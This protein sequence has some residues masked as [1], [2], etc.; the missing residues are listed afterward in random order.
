[1]MKKHD[2]KLAKAIFLSLALSSVFAATAGAADPINFVDFVGDTAKGGTIAVTEDTIV[3]TDGLTDVSYSDVAIS[4][5]TINVADGKKLTLNDLNTITP[6]ITG[7]G[8]I[9]I[10]VPSDS[11]YGNNYYGVVFNNNVNS[12]IKAHDLTITNNNTGWY[13]NAFFVPSGV[14]DNSTMTIE[15]TG[16]LSAFGRYSGYATEGNTKS[17]L[18]IT[19]QNVEIVGNSLG[20]RVEGENNVSITAENLLHVE[21]KAVR[22]VVNNSTGTINLLSNNGNIEAT[23]NGAYDTVRQ[24]NSGGTINLTATKGS[25][26]LSATGSG[27]NVSVYYNGIINI[28]AGNTN[29]LETNSGDAVFTRTDKSDDSLATINI[30]GATNTITSNAKGIHL[31]EGGTVKVESTSGNNEISGSTYAIQ[32]QGG[33]VNVTSAASNT[34]TSDDTAIYAYKGAYNAAQVNINGKTNVITSNDKAINV[35]DAATVTVDGSSTQMTGDI[36]AESSGEATVNFKDAK[37]FLTGTVTT[38]DATTNLNFGSG[39]TWNM[40]GTSNVTNLTL[41]SATV[42][43]TADDGVGSKLTIDKSLTGSGIFKMNLKYLNDDKVDTYIS[44][45]ESDFVTINGQSSGSQ[46]LIFDAE[47]ANLDAMSNTEDNS[48]LFFARIE[49]S[50]SFDTMK[51]ITAVDLSNLYDKEYLLKSEEAG[52][53]SG[54]TTTGKDYYITA[55]ETTKPDPDPTPDPDPDP[56]PTP[57]PSDDDKENENITSAEGRMR[58]TYALATEMD[59]LNKRLGESRY[60]DG[61]KG[62]W[63]RYRHNR[64]GWENAYKTTGNMFQIGYDEQQHDKNDKGKHVIGAAFDYTHAD[65]HLYDVSGHGEHK[66][67][68][69]SLY[70]TWAGEKGHY[71]DIVVRGGVI[72]SDFDVHARTGVISTDSDRNFFGISGEYGYKKNLGKDYYFEPQGQLQW[73]HVGGSGYNTNHGVHVEE[74]SANSFLGRLGF[75]LGKE[76]DQKTQNFYLKADVLHEFAGDQE[77]RLTGRSEKYSEEFNGED[78]WFDIGVGTNLKLS[79][80]STFWLDV[81]RVLGSDYD[82]TWQVNGGFRWEF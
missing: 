72:D 38:T 56:D 27:D 2:K 46:T 74:A 29:I 52:T 50:A 14:K 36:L 79:K 64:T 10:N 65:T 59:R 25:N 20:I 54:Q 37:S 73:T 68:G 69:F 1:M 9:E 17:D 26:I 4:Q 39:S 16:D 7:N 3:N 71:R 8:D 53:S 40:T 34:I 44:S 41:N 76:N 31:R 48:K 80:T 32:A 22:A 62:V 49:G 43:M 13:G 51:P 78:T 33:I 58:A 30:K 61:E 21:G 35:S 57:D 19:A 77:Y 28:T 42:D 66:R 82:R 55:K 70:D 67:Y 18:T 5:Y 63:V 24:S 81:E 6:Q 60:L 75:R 15:L 47:N 45:A 12:V 11:K 23:S